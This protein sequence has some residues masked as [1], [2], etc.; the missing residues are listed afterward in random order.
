LQTLLKEHRALD[1]EQ[2]PAESALHSPADLMKAIVD[3][4]P[5]RPALRPS[6]QR[7]ISCYGCGFQPPG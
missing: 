5:P 3:T 7:L 6:A 4:E 1:E 2:H